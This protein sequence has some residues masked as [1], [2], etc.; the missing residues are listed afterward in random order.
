MFG[1]IQASSNSNDTIEGT[2][3]E[4]RN[5]DRV[6]AVLLLSSTEN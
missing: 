4:L 6:R 5:L 1:E 2:D 3:N